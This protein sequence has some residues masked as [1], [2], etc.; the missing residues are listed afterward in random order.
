MPKKKTT[1]RQRIKPLAVVTADLHLQPLAWADR[2]RVVGDTYWAFRQIIAL[3]VKHQAPRIIVAGDLLDT[4]RHDTA[5]PR[6]V[7]QLMDE[8][9]DSGI[10][11]HYVQG[12]H[13]RLDTPWLSLLM[14]HSEYVVHHKPEDF[15]DI[16]VQCQFIDWQPPDQL[17]W[18][19][20]QVRPETEVLV[21]HQTLDELTGGLFVGEMTAAQVPYAK[22]LL[23]GDIHRASIG[24]YTGA[25]GQDLKV[26]SPGA[27]AKQAIDE[28]DKPT[29]VLLGQDLDTGE[30][31]TMPLPL[32]CRETLRWVVN[33][34]DDVERLLVDL[35][36]EIEEAKERMHRV[37]APAEIA[38]YPL[39]AIE[40]D[41]TELTHWR[42]ITRAIG[43]TAELFQQIRGAVS[44]P[45]SSD[46]EST[47]LPALPS[48]LRLEIVQK[49]IPAAIRQQ[50][51][52][53]AEQELLLQLWQSESPVKELRD[54][55][56]ADG[57]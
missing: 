48:A 51:T 16:G 46:P 54:L 21:M 57:L 6:D 22:M 56:T 25:N 7:Q 47:E 13:D 1:E 45:K 32:H 50:V 37:G 38:D 5:T 33:E 55:L 14:P 42:R 20:H 35:P 30:L 53:P 44:R 40:I 41:E 9:Q 19:L 11:L 29:V 26:I 49:G 39:V 4:K 18:A 23:I 8:L 12:D 15:I 3:A 24:H 34:P 27:P 10:F 43:Q 28:T 36:K 17:Q 2:R 31:A 52:D